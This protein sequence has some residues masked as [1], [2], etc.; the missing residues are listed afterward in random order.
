MDRWVP[1]RIFLWSGTG[2][3]IVESAVLRCIIIGYLFDGL[4]QIHFLGEACKLLC[5]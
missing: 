4:A 5:H 1:I 3:V 2:T